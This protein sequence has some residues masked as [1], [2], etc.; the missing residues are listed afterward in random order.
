MKRNHPLSSGI[1]LLLATA[2]FPSCRKEIYVPVESERIV[3]DTVHR[4]NI[5]MDSIIMRDSVVIRTAGDTIVKE[6]WRIREKVKLVNDTVY[7]SKTDSVVKPVIVPV[8]KKVIERKFKWLS[9]EALAMAAAILLLVCLLL[10]R[11]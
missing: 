9:A 11:R 2:L 1:L 7:Q 3:T 4:I 10:K 6:S 8:E 5:R